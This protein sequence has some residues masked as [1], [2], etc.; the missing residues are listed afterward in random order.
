MVLNESVIKYILV[1]DILFQQDE[2]YNL[3]FVFDTK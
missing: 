2:I 3:L 1:K